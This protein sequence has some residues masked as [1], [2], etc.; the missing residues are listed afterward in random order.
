VHETEEKPTFLTAQGI[1][2]ILGGKEK[3]TKKVTTIKDTSQNFM[4]T[5]RSGTQHA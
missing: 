3:V 2:E 1:E 5:W 4:E